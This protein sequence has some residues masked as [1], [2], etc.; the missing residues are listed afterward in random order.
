M[1]TA[2]EGD[3]SSLVSSTRCMNARR[4]EDGRCV[5]EEEEGRR[6]ARERRVWPS[7]C[8]LNSGRHALVLS[9]K[10]ERK[11]GVGESSHL[12]IPVINRERSWALQRG[13]TRS[14]AFKAAERKAGPGS[15]PR[16]ARE[17]RVTLRSYRNGWVG[18][19]VSYVYTER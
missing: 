19:S 12:A 6:E 17:T 9:K 8:G 1:S 11:E 16:R 7:P 3:I 2:S 5:E 4:K 18:G 13:S 15:L 10:E 14:A